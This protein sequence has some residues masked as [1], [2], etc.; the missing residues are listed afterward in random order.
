MFELVRQGVLAT[1]TDSC[2]LAFLSVLEVNLSLSEVT[3]TL[4]EFDARTKSHRL[5]LEHHLWIVSFVYA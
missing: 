2:L 4:H 5:L 1:A 3:L